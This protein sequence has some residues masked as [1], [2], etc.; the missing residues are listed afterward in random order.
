VILGFQPRAKAP[1]AVTGRYQRIPL[2]GTAKDFDHLLDG[3]LSRAVELGMVGSGLGEVFLAPM[4]R[5]KKAGVVA[6]DHLLL[7]GMGEPG[8]FGADD[9]RYLLSNV[10]V[11]VKA[12][13]HDQFST[14]LIGSRRGELT[15]ERAVRGMLGGVVDGFERF[16]GI[17][18]GIQEE[19]ERFRRQADKALVISLVETDE[20]KV[21]AI[22]QAL[23]R[24]EEEQPI[25]GLVLDFERGDDV[26]G[27]PADEQPSPTDLPPEQERTTLMRITRTGPDRSAAGSRP[28]L[29]VFQFSALGES[30]TITVRE[31]G[32]QTYFVQ[33]L[34]AR[35]THARRRPEQE[36][37]G[38]F[39]TN[40][41]IPEDFRRLIQEGNQLTLV[42]DDTTAS[43]PWEMGAYRGHA[44]TC[45]F[46]TDLCLTRQFRTLLSAAPGVPPPLN[47]TLKVLVIADPFGNLAGARAEGAAVAEVFTQAQRNWG[48]TFDFQVT[49]RLGPYA[50]REALRPRL[51]ELRGDGAVVRSAE[52]CD[53]FELLA[54]MVNEEYDVVHYCG[55][56][57]F[58]PESGRMGW[59][60]DKDCVLS[61]QEIF[62]VRQV[63]RLVFANACLSAVTR[64]D[65]QTQQ[66]QQ[67][68]LAQAFFARGI[69]NYIGT[70]WAVD[71]DPARELAVRFYR[72][73]LGRPGATAPPATLGESLAGARSALLERGL[74]SST[75]GAYQHYGRANDK[76]LPVR[77]ADDE[78]ND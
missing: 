67:V 31:V 45:F 7:M 1:I 69:Q 57:V 64:E 60:F 68:G 34:P 30:A 56:G 78:D 35:L 75:W 20:L 77:N 12:M 61:A 28:G 8:R 29:S 26:P 37:T 72:Q 63:P 42:V 47:E 19:P 73:A 41:L 6:A 46:G 51:D 13:G 2:A 62:R 53:P 74:P 16:R 49:L 66:Q 40:F 76:L 15:V 24:I 55:H 9:L 14:S 4:T 5:H 65:H 43:Y 48:K 70:G 21:C 54:L 58:D 52:V 3:W 71:D 38:L 44:G 27:P 17:L 25:P 36:A 10:T 33:Q 59:L 23:K 50:E 32:V 11:A 39:L 18:T 22:L